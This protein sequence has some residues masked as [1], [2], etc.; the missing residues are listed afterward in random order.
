[1]SMAEISARY[2]ASPSIPLLARQT[3]SCR[4]TPISWCR[5][6]GTAPPRCGRRVRRSCLFC[7]VRA[8]APQ[9]APPPAHPHKLVLVR[10]WMRWID[11]V[12]LFD[13]FGRCDVEVDGDGLVV[14]ADQ[15]AFE[16]LGVRGVDLLVRDIRRHIDEVA[17][18]GLGGELELVAPAHAGA[19]LHNVDHALE[20]AVV[21]RAGL[22]V[23]VDG[24]G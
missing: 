22:G 6:C 3:C 17:G 15:H 14:G 21:M 4:A 20:M 7:S 10:V 8:P 13:L 1:M 11:P 23:G 2:A 16:R 9:K 18:S 5:T 24:H 19:A 12:D